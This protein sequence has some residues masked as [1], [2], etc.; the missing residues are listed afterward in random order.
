MP[1]WITMSQYSMNFLLLPIPEYPLLECAPNKII[2]LVVLGGS[3]VGK[4]AASRLMF[5]RRIGSGAGLILRDTEVQE[6]FCI[7]SERNQVWG[8]AS[9]RKASPGRF[10]EV[11][12]EAHCPGLV[13]EK[14]PG[15]T[16]SGE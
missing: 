3:G 7:S 14:S 13:N 16:I 12:P 1:D 10:E 9:R 15:W 5:D 6:M 11:S 2:K 4:T 8:R